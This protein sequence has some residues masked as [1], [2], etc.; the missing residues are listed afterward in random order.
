MNYGLSLP[1]TKIMKEC[2]PFL[3]ILEILPS[4]HVKFSYLPEKL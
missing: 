3:K 4:C 1:S 2:L